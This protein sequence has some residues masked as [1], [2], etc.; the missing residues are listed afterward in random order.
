MMLSQV[1]AANRCILSTYFSADRMQKAENR[2]QHDVSSKYRA[3]VCE[4]CQHGMQVA[5]LMLPCKYNMAIKALKKL[6]NAHSTKHIQQNVSL[7][8]ASASSSEALWSS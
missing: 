7:L 6:G 3:V 2:V 4:E 8:T 1:A 5:D